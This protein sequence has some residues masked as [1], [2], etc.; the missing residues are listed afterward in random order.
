[1]EAG[2]PGPAAVRRR[3]WRTGGSVAAVLL[4]IW[5]SACGRDGGAPQ[6]RLSLAGTLGG[7]DTAGYARATAP[8]PFRFPA[9]HGP[10]PDFRTEWWYVTGNVET[11]DGRPV[12]FQLTFFRSALAPTPPTTASPWATNQAWMA[13][14][15]LTDVRGGAFHAFQRF[16]RGAVGLAGARAEPFRVWLG[17]WSLETAD[18]SG[19]HGTFPVRLRAHGG[20][21]AVDLVLEQGKPPVLQ[22]DRGLSRKGPS[23]GNASYYYSLT[24]M[25]ARGAVRIG[26]DT[27][28]ATGDAWLDREWST[29]A[30]SEGE[31]GWDWFALQLDDG[32]DVMVYRIRGRDGAASPFSRGTLVGPGGEASPL[33]LG[34][35]VWVDATGT[36]K[37]PDGAVYPS[38][39]RVRLP[40]RGW[41]LDVRPV[42]DDQELDLAFRYWEGAVRVTARDG[43]GSPVGRGYVELTGYAGDAPGS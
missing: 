15:A 25:P 37:S 32:W 34:E 36:W 1:M 40:R 28:R 21:V 23:P 5:T 18:P 38:G 35:D 24:R 27:L 6:A 7:A 43:S 13:H 30:L 19:S 20:D 3:A 4:W 17:D 14:F 26:A 11:S 2:T 39:W 42:L 9:D 31:A 22:G 41:D 12:G 29:S 8:R 33:V 16:D 10:H